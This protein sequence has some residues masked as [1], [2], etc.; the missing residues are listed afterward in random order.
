MTDAIVH[1]RIPITLCVCN[2]TPP[3]Q[4]VIQMAGFR[5]LADEEEVEF[6][7]AKSNKGF[8]AVEVRGLAGGEC[9]GSHRRPGSKKKHKKVR[10]YN[11]GE[12]ANHLAS[13]CN[14]APMPKRCHNCKSQDH[15]IE[16][17][18]TL[19]EEKKREAAVDTANAVAQVVKK[20]GETKKKVPSTTSP[21]KA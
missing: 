18:P 20:N 12:F 10:C 7:A 15:L 3:L 19:P 2:S 9:K 17:C 21:K 5:S 4:S 8:E 6:R 14:M 1:P 13:Q 11:C 16:N